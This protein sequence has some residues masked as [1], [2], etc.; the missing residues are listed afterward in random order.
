MKE[1]GG[2]DNRYLWTIYCSYIKAIQRK[3]GSEQL[4]LDTADEKER[5]NFLNSFKKQVLYH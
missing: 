2:A 3:T 1:R 4:K 5:V